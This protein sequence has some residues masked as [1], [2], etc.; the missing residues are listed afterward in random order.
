MLKQVSDGSERRPKAPHGPFPT[1][2]TETINQSLG[3]IPIPIN[4][5][6]TPIDK[7][8]VNKMRKK[9]PSS[10]IVSEAVFVP[11]VMCVKVVMDSTFWWLKR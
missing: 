5:H 4:S 3:P 10:A 7:S 11:S 1:A 9:S 8:V 2:T 6:Q